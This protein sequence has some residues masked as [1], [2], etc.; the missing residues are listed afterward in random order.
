MAAV[1]VLSAAHA[2]AHDGESPL[3]EAVAEAEGS[4]LLGF[5]M[6]QGEHIS[7]DAE[8]T[9]ATGRTVTLGD[10]T[11]GGARPLVL[12]LMYYECPNLCGQIVITNAEVF[13]SVSKVAG[14]D[15]QLVTV[16]ISPTEGAELAAEK[17]ALAISMAPEGFPAD[18]WTFLVGEKE[19]IDLLAES[20]G[21]HYRRSG[22]EYDHPLGL[23]FVSPRGKITSYVNGLDYVPAEIALNVMSASGGVVTPAVAKVLRLCFSYSPESDSLV[24]SVDKVTGGV[25]LTVAG[26][27]GIFLVRRSRQRRERISESEGRKRSS[28]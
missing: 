10:L 16:S 19:N 11:A 8:F 24:F 17:K 27:F 1:L 22:D 9:D 12:S 25:T 7:L 21:F 15:Y 2:F 3:A 14:E 18:G 20:V 6:R 26:V 5:D 28:E 4:S 13:G 23:V